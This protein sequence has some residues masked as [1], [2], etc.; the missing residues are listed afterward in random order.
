[1][2]NNFTPDYPQNTVVTDLVTDG[3]NE[4][5]KIT[6]TGL[7]DGTYTVTFDGE[8][9]SA[10]DA[11]VTAAQ[12]RGKLE[13]LSNLD[14]GD[15]AVTGNA[16]G[17]FTLTFQGNRAKENVPQVTVSATKGSPVVETLTQ[18]SADVDNPDAVVRGTGNADAT[19][20]VSPLEGD[21]PV[22]QRAADGSSY[23]DA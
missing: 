4:V 8:T 15:I 6:L 14:V 9:T 20:R 5:Q 23:G 1:M 3:A 2:T 13:G 10:S 17:P 22:E 21:S 12:L 18:G 7:S 11:S 19:E 16:G